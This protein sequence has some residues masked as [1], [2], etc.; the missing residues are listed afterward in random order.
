MFSDVYKGIDKSNENRVVALKVTIPDELRPP[1]DSI[2]EASIL[3]NL[4]QLAKKE[5]ASQENCY[6]VE[7]L[8]SWLESDGLDEQ[9]TVVMPFLEFDLNQ[10]LAHYRTPSSNLDPSELCNETEA[11][12]TNKFPVSKGISIIK[13]LASALN[14]IHAQGIIHRDVKPHNILFE[15]LDESCPLRLVDFDISW[16]PPDNA[17]KEPADEKITDVG[18]GTY[19]SPEL[20]FGIGNYGVELDMWAFGCI[21]CQLFSLQNQ[22]PPFYNENSM[23]SDI[24]LISTIFGTLG[25]PSVKTWPEVKDVPSFTHMNF[26]PDS[27]PKTFQELA[28]LAP[29]AVHEELLPKMLCYSAADR[30]SAEAILSSS[31]FH[32]EDTK[33][34]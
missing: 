13:Q 26:K 17:T 19:R 6:V 3:K 31:L 34:K 11:N 15:T 33:M 21:V 2:K 23:V 4:R 16:V 32:D 20:L 12:F 8:D 25:V 27:P 10:V 28:P 29:S 1:H 14:F 18:S 24:A 30:I 5:G 22:H 7:L 9:L